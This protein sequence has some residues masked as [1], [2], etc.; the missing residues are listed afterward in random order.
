MLVA[1]A[2]SGGFNQAAATIHKSQS[3]IHNAVKK[4]ESALNLPLFVIEGKKTKLTPS[5]E[6]LYRRATYLLQEAEKVESIG[7]LLAEGVESKLNIA[8]DEMFPHHWLCDALEQ[9]S[10]AFPFLRVEIFESVLNG[11]NEQL[12]NG[13]VDIAISSINNHSAYNEQICDIEFVAVASPQHPLHQIPSPLSLE[14]LKTHRQIVIRDSALGKNA[15]LGWLGAHQRWTVS[16]I[17]TS[18]DMLCRGL[19]FAWLPMTAI[20]PL[21]ELGDVQRL[22]LKH[23]ATRTVPL[24]LLYKDDD[25]LGP[26]AQYFVHELRTRCRKGP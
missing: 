8:V 14:H 11:A 12:Q 23:G 2:D 7:Q 9:T 6:L 5:G 21:L 1:V 3:S 13:L 20:E 25:M 15:D 19:G 16:N 4:I 18:L 10:N 24:Y 17:K 22:N 26:A